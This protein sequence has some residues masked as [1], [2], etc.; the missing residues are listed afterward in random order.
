MS[1]NSKISDSPSAPFQT[2]FTLNAQGVL[3]SPGWLA[4]LNRVKRAMSRAGGITVEDTHANRLDTA[5]YP[6]AKVDPTTTLY[7]T[8]RQ[9][10]YRVQSVNGTAAW[11]YQRGTMTDVFAN[12][13]TDLGPNDAGFLWTVSDYCHTLQWTGT[14]WQAAPGIV[15]DGGKIE[16]FLVDPDALSGWHLCDGSVVNYLKQDGSTVAITLP[17]MVSAPGKA[18]Y[19]KFGATASAGLNPATAAI[20]TL[21]PYVPTG[22]VS[23]PNFEGDS[24]TTN[25]V[26]AGTPAGTNSTPVF[27]GTSGT[28]ASE[29][30]LSYANITISGAVQVTEHPHTHTFTPAGTVSAPTFSGTALAGHSHTVTVTGTISTPTFLGDPANLSGTVSATAEPQNVAVRPFFRL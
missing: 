7:E 3:T 8:D 29:P 14:G 5:R 4:W 26:S 12:K 28:T 15:W 25:S 22:T 23:Q 11:V 24:V 1:P 30:S 10:Y 13:P 2:P 27:S 18:S 20:L 21:D 6:L 16:G 17:D 19:L 9:V